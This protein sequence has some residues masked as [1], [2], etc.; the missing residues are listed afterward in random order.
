M[1]RMNFRAVL[2]V[3]A[4]FCAVLAQAQYQDYSRMGK[5]PAELRFIE[6]PM[7]VELKEP[8]WL[9]HSPKKD[10]PAEQ[11][12]YA[13]ALEREGK[14]EKAAEAY[15]D[16]VHEWHATPEAL[17]AQLALARIWSSLGEAQKAY[18]ADIYLLAHFNGRFVLEPVLKDA[19]AQADLLTAREQGR[20]FSTTSRKALREN[21]ERIIHFAP[22]WPRVPELLLRIA[23]LYAQQ[24]EYA[25]A[26]TVCDRILVDWPNCAKTDEAVRAYCQACR[27]QANTWANDVGRLRHLEGLIAGARTFRP[28]HPDVA[29]FDTWRRE[30]YEMRR[31]KSYAQA[32]FYD[33]PAAYSAE[34]AQLAYQAFL[35]EFP[36][37]PQAPAVRT[38]LAELSL[39]RNTPAAEPGTAPKESK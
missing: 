5:T 36:D 1:R 19:V 31:A 8:S 21:Y 3:S 13:A 7:E 24:G 27:N 10:T 16:L 39:A 30:I 35:R 26:I 12:A 28:G 29:L 18:D 11:L 6:D 22:R 32:V 38:R 4:A 33:N 14:P 34:A 9:W 2:A 17:T 37:A 15:D 23:L 25:S 20:T